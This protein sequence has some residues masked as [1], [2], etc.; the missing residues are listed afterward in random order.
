CLA[1]LGP[2]YSTSFGPTGP[3]PHKCTGCSTLYSLV[4]GPACPKCKFYIE[5]PQGPSISAEN[6]IFK[7]SHWMGSINTSPGKLAQ[8]NNPEKLSRINNKVRML[9]QVVQGYLAAANLNN[10][11]PET[12]LFLE[13]SWRYM[14]ELINQS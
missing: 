3:M 11:S 14:K 13:H 9:S 12:K 2:P 4:S 7:G 10:P 6:I 1:Y 5:V 8:A